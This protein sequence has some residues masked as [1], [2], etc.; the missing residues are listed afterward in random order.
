MVVDH[1]SLRGVLSRFATGVTVVAT[2]HRGGGVCG[3]TA[4]A[5]TSVS[6][7]PPLVLVCVDRN[8][9]TYGCIQRF[10]FFAA[11]FLA[12]GQHD[13]SHRFAQRRDD[14]FEVV[15]YRTGSTGAPI[16]AGS[17]GSVE[18]LI[19]AEYPGGDHGIF[20]ARVV[21]AEAGNGLPLVFYRGSYTTVA[22]ESPGSEPLPG[23]PEEA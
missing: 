7:D 10:G 4:N 15:E 6:L 12:Q 14:K 21:A 22:S 20:L 8:S 9:N 23:E 5:F 19:E 16:L 11:S 3:L 17:V 2:L 1:T 13:L 18:A